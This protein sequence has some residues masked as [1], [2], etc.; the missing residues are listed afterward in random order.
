MDNEMNLKTCSISG[1]SR[2]GICFATAS[3]ISKCMLLRNELFFWIVS[4]N[5]NSEDSEKR[6][7]WSINSIL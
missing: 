3:T 4:M 5:I 7:L 2:K 1:R 6:T